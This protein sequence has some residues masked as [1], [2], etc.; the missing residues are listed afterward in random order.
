MSHFDI[1][2]YLFKDTF[3]SFKGMKL[4]VFV[5]FALH[6]SIV[7]FLLFAGEYESSKP[8]KKMKF[9][10]ISA[11]AAPLQKGT[12]E[13]TAKG[14]QSK[15]TTKTSNTKEVSKTAPTKTTPKKTSSVPDPKAEQIKEPEKKPEEKPEKKPEKKSEQ[16]TE[17]QPKKESKEPEKKKPSREEL[18]QQLQSPNAHENGVQGGTGEKN[19]SPDGT[20]HAPEGPAGIGN[21]DPILAKYIQDCHNTIF[22]NWAVNGALIQ[23]NPELE[24]TVKV[25]VAE[26]GT[27]SNPEIVV[28][29]G[30]RSFDKSA[31]MAMLKTKKL[32]SPPIK[33]RASAQAGVY[34]TLSAQDK[35]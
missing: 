5:S 18:L 7:V 30:N 22:P 15:Q 11:V 35:L 4:E 34:I 2:I 33:Y 24:V 13:R 6:I 20:D 19:R 3:V 26:D 32:P 31:I 10:T 14:K 8:E 25:F 28:S 16:K 21:V 27:V 17:D 12:L 1:L 9:T 23:Q 29:S